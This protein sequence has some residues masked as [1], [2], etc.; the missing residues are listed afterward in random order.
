MSLNMNHNFLNVSIIQPHLSDQLDVNLSCLESA[1]DSLSSGYVKPELVV[2]VEFGIARKTPISLDHEALSFLG[3]LAKKHHIYFVPGTFAEA[4][5]EL[6]QGAFYNT[7]PVFGP[8]GTM[9]TYY[10][11]KV[12]FRPGEPSTPSGTNDYCLFD[13]K[14]K[15]IKVGVI[16]CY[17]QF[18]PEIPRTVALMGADIILCP[19]MDP[20]EYKHIPDII[21]RARA[22]ENELFYVWTC[23]VGQSG[24]STCCGKSTI[25]NPEGEIVFQ[26]S[27]NPEY[28]TQT[29]DLSMT[30][31]KRTLGRD[32]H[33]NSLRAFRVSYP[34]ANNLESA[35]VYQTL[36][37]LTHTKEE[38][39]S[40]ILSE[41][42]AK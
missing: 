34:F 9:I 6:P 18:F 40:R 39:I 8:D 37:Q 21:P 25:V 13:I 3:S 26:C 38:Y 17:E 1:L 2:G 14:E 32:Q 20:M 41:Q 35:P 19:A 22:L 12:P 28:I 15:N 27:H 5:P 30:Q 42:T 33:L 7:C 10:R 31:V 29:L 11:K 16:I 4:S 23:G 36:P 24:A